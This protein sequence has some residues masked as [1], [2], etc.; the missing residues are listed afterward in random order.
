MLEF[1]FWTAGPTSFTDAYFGEGSGPVFS[2]LSCFTGRESHITEC[3]MGT[4]GG[5][6]CQ[7]GRL[8]CCSEMSFPWCHCE[9]SMQSDPTSTRVSN[10]LLDWFHSI[11]YLIFNSTQLDPHNQGPAHHP[12]HG[13]YY[14]TVSKGVPPLLWEVSWT[15][16]GIIL[17]N[18]VISKSCRANDLQQLTIH[19]HVK[20]G[21]FH[22][23]STHTQKE[24]WPQ[25]F[26]S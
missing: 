15:K 14:C 20:V 1:S 17:I 9:T 21:S 2:Y 26:Q 7:H 18:S 5:V 25:E 4:V 16:F 8:G 23:K 13:Y 12:S 6:N 3:S 19:L 22:V 24:S 10:L 11:N